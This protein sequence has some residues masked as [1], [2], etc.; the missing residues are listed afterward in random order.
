MSDHPANSFH[1]PTPEEVAPYFP[2]YVLE[3][4]LGCGGMGAVYKA[5]HTFFNRD[6]AIK[7]LL[8]KTF[9]EEE[10]YRQFFA[11][12]QSMSLLDHENLLKIYDYGEVEGIPFIILEYVHGS[13]L[14]GAISV[15]G[16]EPLQTAQIMMRVCEGLAHAHDANIWHRDLKPENILIDNYANPK[17]ADFGLARDEHDPV[18]DKVIWG[19]PGYIAPEIIHAPEKVDHRADIYALGCVLYHMITGQIPDPNNTN[20]ERFNYIDPRF[21]YILD[22]SMNPHVEHRY[23]SAMDMGEAFRDLILSLDEIGSNGNLDYLPV[24]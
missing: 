10:F 11:E 14:H 7:L 22:R 9:G 3:S 4:V 24:I 17:I 20:Y 21:R 6:V 1:V 18:K 13:E 12:A 23:L 16:V 19:S 5:H 8:S 15:H 2:D